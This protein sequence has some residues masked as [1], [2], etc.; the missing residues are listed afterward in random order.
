MFTIFN[1]FISNLY[2]LYKNS[3]LSFTSICSLLNRP[4]RA[5]KPT[6]GLPGLTLWALTEAPQ[7][8]QGFLCLLKSLLLI[9]L[10]CQQAD[11]WLEDLIPV[12][13]NLILHYNSDDEDLCVE[14]KVDFCIDAKSLKKKTIYWHCSLNL[15]VD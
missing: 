8:L 11:L 1:N 4:I 9:L 3:L 10:L 2:H 6:D 13:P 7:L 5:P 15:N 14:M 12:R